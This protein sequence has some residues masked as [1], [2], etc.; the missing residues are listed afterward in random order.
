MDIVS[1]EVI[2]LFQSLKF[3]LYALFDWF[4][5]ISPSQVYMARDLKTGEIVALKKIR[6]DNEKEGV[7]DNIYIYIF[8]SSF[9]VKSCRLAV[10][11]G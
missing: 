11:H 2:L 8:F 7:S 4:A 5:P 1:Y 10:K 3:S 6:M 9:L